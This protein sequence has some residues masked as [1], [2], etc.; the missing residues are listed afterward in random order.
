MTEDAALAR[1][2]AAVRR[3]NE[4]VIVAGSEVAAQEL[5][6]PEFVN[7]SAAPNMPKGQVGMLFTFSKILRPAFPDLRV[8]IHDQIAEGDQVTTRKTLGGPHRGELLGIAPTGK[9]VGIDVID[10]VRLREGPYVEHC[11]INTL[12]AV[13]AQLRSG[14]RD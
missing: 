10:I 12:P 13:L 4:E 1:N 11:G 6:D 3:F 9:Q 7:H 14:S 2:K 8:A 5:F